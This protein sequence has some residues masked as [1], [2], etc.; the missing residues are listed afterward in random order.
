MLL[1]PLL[2]LALPQDHAGHSHGAPQPAP[3]AAAPQAPQR[4]YRYRITPDRAVIVDTLGPREPKTVTY[5]VAN[6]SDKPIAFTVSDFSPG[7]TATLEAFAKPFAP[8]DV[9]TFTVTVDPTDWVGWQTRA[10]RIVPDD[11]NEPTFKTVIKLNIRPE[12]AVDNLAKDLGAVA[13]HES[14]QIV[15]AFNREGGDPG[16][17]KLASQ[18]PPWFD[19]EVV[20][21]G[22]HSELRLTFRPRLL[23]PGVHAGLELIKVETNAPRQPSFPLTLAWKLD[24]PVVPSPARVVFD[25]KDAEG[26]TLTLAAKDGKPFR[27]LSAELEGKG[28]AVGTFP[29]GNPVDG[30]VAPLPQ[31]PAKDVALPVKVLTTTECKAVLVLHLEGHEEPLK[32]PLA[33]LPP[34][35]PGKAVKPAPKTGK[36]AKG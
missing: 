30:Q 34:S 13:P 15:F 26:Q 29:D 31:A 6:Q 20:N 24:L 33:Y 12:M 10:V 16:Q 11:P 3:Q 19:P 5:E 27:I 1:L 22:T 8:G 36:K 17:I 9:R 25:R 7:T 14:P 4:K 18:L 35:A 2:L 32:V 23:N 21:E 28:F